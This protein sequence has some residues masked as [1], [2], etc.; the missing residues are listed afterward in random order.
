MAGKPPTAEQILGDDHHQADEHSIGDAHKAIASQAVATEDEAADDG[1]KQIVGEAH[2]A[3]DAQV[4]EDSA[5][6]FKGIPGR[7]YG[8]DDHHEDAEV[9][10]GREPQGYLPEIHEAQHQYSKD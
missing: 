9:A 6:A 4:M 3:E 10:D 1:L 8:R 7:D 5:D 2:P